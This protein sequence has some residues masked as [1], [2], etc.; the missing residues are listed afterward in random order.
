MV[1]V[2]SHVHFWL[3]P[4]LSLGNPHRLVY[5][6]DLGPKDMLGADTWIHSKPSQWGYTSP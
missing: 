3:F 5:D 1:L 6:I 2:N 4:Y